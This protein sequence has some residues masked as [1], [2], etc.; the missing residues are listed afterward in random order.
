MVAHDLRNPLFVILG[1]ADMIAERAEGSLTREAAGDITRAAA[2]MGRLVTDLL[3]L[4]RIDAGTFRLDKREHSVP[5]LLSEMHQSYRPM[6]DDRGVTLSVDV[7][8][9]DLVAS[10]DHDRVVQVLSNLLGNAMKFTPRG[11]KV[12]LQVEHDVGELVL[13][14]RDDGAGIE[15]SSLPHLFERFWQRDSDT[16]RGLGLG[17]YLCR[18]IARAHGGDISVQSKVGAGS[19]FRVWLPMS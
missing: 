19:T 14:V 18:V 8:P 15:P 11:G 2:R 16:R 4:V 1:N 6:F 10:F 3:D 17:L 7:P 13:A 5:S 9:A 12:D